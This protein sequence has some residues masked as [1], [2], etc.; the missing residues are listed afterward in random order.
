MVEAPPEVR[1]EVGGAAAT[2]DFAT[3]P[4]SADSDELLR[5]TAQRA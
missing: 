5:N 4:T 3:L 2:P 1:E